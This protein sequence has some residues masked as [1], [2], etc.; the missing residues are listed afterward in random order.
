MC[1]LKNSS[2]Y[3]GESKS[4]L[5]EYETTRAFND[6]TRKVNDVKVVKSMQIFEHEQ[7][8]PLPLHEHDDQDSVNDLHLLPQHVPVDHGDVVQV[9]PL[10]E[11]DDDKEHGVNDLIPLIPACVID[12]QLLP[13]PV[14]QGGG[15]AQHDIAEHPVCQVDRI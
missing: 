5:S 4:R 15:D 9:E 8:Q 7:H 12:L 11:P 6:D 3:R 2:V 10:Y 14:D 1:L 13:Q